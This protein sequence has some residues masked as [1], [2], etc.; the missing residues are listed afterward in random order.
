MHQIFSLIC[1]LKESIHIYKI[2]RVLDMNKFPSNV[3]IVRR[4]Q[5]L[6]EI[7]PEL[8]MPQLRKILLYLQHCV[9]SYLMHTLFLN[10]R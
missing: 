1:F 6:G 3:R 2:L 7:S 8:E 10:G 5:Y 4:L 9:E